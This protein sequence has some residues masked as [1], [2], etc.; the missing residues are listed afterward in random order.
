MSSTDAQKF[1]LGNGCNLI[2][3]VCSDRPGGAGARATASLGSKSP[4]W[5]QGCFPPHRVQTNLITPN[6]WLVLVASSTQDG[7]LGPSADLS[8]DV[9]SPALPSLGF[10]SPQMPTE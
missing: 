7:A 4:E 9:P 10:P 6:L 2:R 5:R 8:S 1:Y 3:G